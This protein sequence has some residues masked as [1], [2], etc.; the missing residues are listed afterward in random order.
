MCKGCEGGRW[1]SCCA[2]REEVPGKAEEEGEEEEE[3]EDA[4]VSGSIAQSNGCGH[5]V[6]GL[7]VHDV[8]RISFIDTH[9]SRIHLVLNSS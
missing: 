1:P 3:Q 4:R 6:C 2:E 7:L 8:A 9:S 5:F